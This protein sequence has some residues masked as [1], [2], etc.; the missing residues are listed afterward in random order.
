MKLLLDQNLSRRIV[1][2]VAPYYPK[3]SQ[4]ALLKMVLR[5]NASQ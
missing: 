4:V 5:R 3:S 1:K 2:Q